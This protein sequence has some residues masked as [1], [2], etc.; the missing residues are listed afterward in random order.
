M[1]MSY[2]AGITTPEHFKQISTLKVIQVHVDNTSV[3]GLGMVST[4]SLD[5]TIL[6]GPYLLSLHTYFHTK[7]LMPFK[8]S[9]LHSYI[10]K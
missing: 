10:L 1:N 5:E 7:G 2:T 4:C 9:A 3:H 8:H 6:P